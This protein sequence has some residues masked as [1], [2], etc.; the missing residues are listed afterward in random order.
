[1]GF[2]RAGNRTKRFTALSCLILPETLVSSAVQGY[3]FQV[4]KVDFRSVG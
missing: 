2:Q 3:V 1:M 4:R